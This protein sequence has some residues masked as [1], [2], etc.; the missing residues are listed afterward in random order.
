[1]I[2]LLL[3]TLNS[4][5]DLV[6]AT[7]SYDNIGPT[8]SLE[9]PTR[10][11]FTNTLG[12]RLDCSASGIPTP[13]IEWFD[14]ENNP[15]NSIAN[16]RHIFP[17]GSIY[18]PPF[19][20]ESFR[21]DVH[22]ST[23]KCVAVNSVGTI[24]SRDVFVKAVIHQRYDL[25]VQNPGGFIGSNV[26]IKCIIPQFVKDYVRVTSWLEEPLYNI[27]PTLEG[28]SKFHMLP[29]GELVV[30]NVTQYDAQKA[31]RC[32]TLHSLTQDVVISN[33][34][35]RIQLTEMKEP[36]PPIMNDKIK[37]ITVRLK[38][39]VVI[40]CVAYANPKPI[41]RWYYRNKHGRNE[42]IEHIVMTTSGRYKVKES[43]L[44][45]QSIEQSDNAIFYCIATNEQGSETLEIQLK[46]VAP[47]QA[48][49]QPQRQTVD[50]GKSADLKCMI[51]GMPQ[52]N[53]WWIKD[54]Q[55]L[56]TG[57]RVRIISK[58]QIHI[59]SISKDDQGMFQCFVKNDVD[60]AQGVAEI[61]LGEIA[62][63][64]HYR[65]IE[66]T[67][68]PGP[69]VS[70][71]C[72]GTGSPTPQISWTLDG[73]PLPNNDRLMIGQY[74]TL[75]GDVVSHVNITNVKAEDGGEY[76]CIARSRAGQSSHSA[77]LNIYGTPFVRSMPAISAVAGKTLQI[78]C[79]VAGWPIDKIIWEKNNVKLPTNM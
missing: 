48:H 65:F 75:S 47:L 43:R 41:Y 62:P 22:W 23:Y 18:F 3:L 52:A 64:L 19:Q 46:I 12:S 54:G 40:P 69:G 1:M 63:I 34:V 60:M 33:S 55:P 37:Y 30:I 7:A 68:Q 16:I 17:N 14:N 39:S 58:D 56:R 74:V 72:T 10:F 50:V 11:D 2:F 20:G 79:P 36:V 49:I 32:R 78:K 27:Y 4:F 44:I 5:S 71:K 45:I 66:Q 57:S 21:Q 13:N 76:S 24:V 70:L 28:D 53:I 26:I 38:E 6:W 31:F 59:T 73:F 51:S 35:G 15:V 67:L 29:T 9:P 25:E 42:S 61:S 8:F 77:R